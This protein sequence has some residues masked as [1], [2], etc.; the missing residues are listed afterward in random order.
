MNGAW[1]WSGVRVYEGGRER[2][3]A[4]AETKDARDIGAATQRASCVVKRATGQET[5]GLRGAP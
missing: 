1:K 3:K 4:G 2:E 5:E